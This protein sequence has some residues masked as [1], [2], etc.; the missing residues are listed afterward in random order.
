MNI[1]EKI[2][3]QAADLREQLQYHNH[4]YYVL[5]DPEVPDSEYDPNG[6]YGQ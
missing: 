4:R 1:P 3:N 6:Y 5:D 2:Q